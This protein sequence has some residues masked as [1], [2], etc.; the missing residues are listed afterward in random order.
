MG[1]MGE[2]RGG[3]EWLSASTPVG[4]DLRAGRCSEASWADLTNGARRWTG[5][6]E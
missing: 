1:R 2:G 5:R 4:S 6:A 3:G